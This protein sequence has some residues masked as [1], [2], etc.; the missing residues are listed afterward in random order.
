MQTTLP[1]RGLKVLDFSTLLPG[2]LASLILAEAGADVFKVERPGT[3]DESRLMS[4]AIFAMLNRKKRSLCVDL[5]DPDAKSGILERIR[6]ADIL[7]EQFRPGVMAR[8]GLGWDD[9]RS[10]NPRLIY[11]SI[12]GYGQ[13]GP[14]A[15]RAG[16]DLNYQAETGLLAMGNGLPNVLLADLMGGAYP[17]VI[18][19][20]LALSRRAQDGKGSCIDLS[21]TDNLFTAMFLDIAALSG[22][23]APSS[24]SRDFFQ[25][26][27]P[28]YQLYET[29]DGRHL[30]LGAIENRFWNRFCELLGIPQRLRDDR[31]NPQKAK[32]AIQERIRAKTAE[33]WEAV[34]AN[35]DVCCS[36]VLSP[37]EAFSSPHFIQRGVFPTPSAQTTARW[38]MLPLPIVKDFCDPA[39]S[40][41]P[42]ELGGANGETWR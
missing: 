14:M 26:E 12:T 22:A 36:L 34:F 11:C 16:H 38:P 3:G 7:I 20:L 4:Q 9:V 41:E 17:A 23:S 25:G 21:M 33:E 37:D 31:Q 2:P 6:D 29:K 13:T 35:E 10:L 8:L 24:I 32:S 39:P 42:P 28:R 18:N 40:K 19:I 1:L 15:H 27:S 30:A 5:A